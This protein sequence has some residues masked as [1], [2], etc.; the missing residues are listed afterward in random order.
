M[1]KLDR[2]DVLK[3]EDKFGKDG[4]AKKIT[5][6][7]AGRTKMNSH[8]KLE[9]RCPLCECVFWKNR[10]IVPETVVV[11]GVMKKQGLRK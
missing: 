2:E 5:A 8:N 11:D 3:L 7:K 10:N 4:A 1:E 9:S 6:W